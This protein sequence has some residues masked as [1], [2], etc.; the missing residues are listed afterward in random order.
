MIAKPF[1]KISNQGN[2]L[3]DVKFN[4]ASDDIDTRF[5][6]VDALGN[7]YLLGWIGFYDGM[8]LVKFDN[9]GNVVW[10]KIILDVSGLPYDLTLDADQ[11]PVICG[12]VYEVNEITEYI[13]KNMIRKEMKFGQ[14]IREKLVLTFKR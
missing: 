13:I 2:V 8:F 1:K 5:M 3:V 9:S 12:K 11:N 14:I 10:D 7:V 6:Q 4:S